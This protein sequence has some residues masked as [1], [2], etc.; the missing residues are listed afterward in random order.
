MH[1]VDLVV[2]SKIPDDPVSADLKEDAER[3]RVRSRVP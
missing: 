2:E 1:T 3:T